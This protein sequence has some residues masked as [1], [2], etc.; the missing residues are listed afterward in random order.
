MSNIKLFE[1]KK[2]RSTWNDQDNKWYFSVADVV[3][4]LTDS[5]DSKAYWRQLKHREP[6]LVTNCHG[7]RNATSGM[8][9]GI[10]EIVAYNVYDLKYLSSVDISYNPA[11]GSGQIQVRDIHYVTS[12]RRTTWE[13]C[14]LLDQKCIASKKGFNEWLRMAK[15][16]G[17]IKSNE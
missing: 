13:F 8:M 4:A 12:T 16:Y 2:I 15:T 1:S 11:L 14:Q 10:M 7:L 17:W 6:E 5:A 9:D 3:G